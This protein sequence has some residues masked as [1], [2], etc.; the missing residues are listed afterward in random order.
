MTGRV[1]LD[2]L[3][4]FIV[5]ADEGSFSAAGRKLLR[6]QSAVSELIGA[7]EEQL[8][9]ELFDR[10]G[11]YPRLTVAGET[12][13]AD[14]RKV[15][16][17]VDTLKARAKGVAAGTEPEL[18]VVV[19]AFYPLDFVTQA[20]GEFKTRYPRTPLRL[21]FESLGAVCQ[22]VMAGH[23]SVGVVGTLPVLP[24]GL[25]SE[26]LH[27]ITMALVAAARHP[28][29]SVRGV[30]SRE[31]LSRHVQLVLTDRSD[32]TQ[33]NEFG[34]LAPETWRLGD[35]FVKK[36]F[37]LAGLGWGG[38]PLSLVKDEL[39]SGALVTLDAEDILPVQLIMPMFAVYRA[40]NLPGPAG[41]WFI[42]R[43]KQ[44]SSDP[45]VVKDWAT[46]PGMRSVPRPT[47][48]RDRAAK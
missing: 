29:A 4:S 34:V 24:E 27:G 7:L 30:V 37:L 14:A 45:S 43:L 8:E 11:R 5:A 25:G 41:R 31:E 20:V 21:Y 23:C 35:I 44:F 26:R 48:Q 16:D 13:L 2:Q 1:S 22:P 38:M 39:A 12:L 46:R 19:D 18:S 3:K 36:A 28:L 42:D 17:Q 15:L 47:R 32:L 33:G 10:S 40:S 6:A 9:V